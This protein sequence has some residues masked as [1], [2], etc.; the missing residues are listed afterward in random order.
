[1]SLPPFLVPLTL[2]VVPGR[3]SPVLG[4]A[5]ARAC[6]GGVGVGVLGGGGLAGLELL[7]LGL[8]LRLIDLPFLA[9]LD[10]SSAGSGRGLGVLGVLLLFEIP[11]LLVHD[12]QPL[13]G[14]VGGDGPGGGGGTGGG[15]FVGG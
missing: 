10:P 13:G 9:P 11:D 12:A 4:A 14:C 7:L 15:G 3:K 8:D 5:L 2:V 1:M 6:V